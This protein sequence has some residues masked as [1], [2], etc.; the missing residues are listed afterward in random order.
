[1]PLSS[2]LHRVVKS[3]R[4]VFTSEFSLF[5]RLDIVLS[6]NAAL[7]RQFELTFILRVRASLRV[8]FAVLRQMV[9]DV[10]TLSF[11]PNRAWRDALEF[12]GVITTI[13]ILVGGIMFA[14]L[15]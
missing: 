6:L 12:P 15:S 8:P 10:P 4:T 3:F 14:S 13:L 11:L 7:K 5:A 9:H 2:I 1:M